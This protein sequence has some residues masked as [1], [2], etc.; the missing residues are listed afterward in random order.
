[1]GELVLYGEFAEIPE[2]LFFK[3][4][5]PDNSIRAYRTYRERIAWYDPTKKDK[6]FLTKWKWFIE[7]LRAIRVAPIDLSEKLL[8][9]LQMSQWFTWNWHLLAKDL[10]KALAWPFFKLFLNFQNN[11]SMR[12]GVK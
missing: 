11:P 10:L 7:Y 12:L 8:C 3:R 4:N 6:L 1:L 5:H 2:P 9:S